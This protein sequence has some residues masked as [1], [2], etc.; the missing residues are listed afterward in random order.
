MAEQ[1]KMVASTENVVNV[2]ATFSRQLEEY[3]RRMRD[4]IANLRRALDVLSH[5][6]TSE[7]FRPFYNSVNDKLAQ[8]EREL[9]SCDSLK[10]YLDQVAARLQA[11]LA[12]LRSASE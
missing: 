7:D 8:I 5:G 10:T 6:W 2:V 9:S 1:N 12:K 11:M 3:K 4:E